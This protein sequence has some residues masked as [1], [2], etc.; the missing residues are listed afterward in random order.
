ME[1]SSERMEIEYLVAAPP[2]DVLR[3]LDKKASSPLPKRWD[4]RLIS[5]LLETSLLARNSRL[6]DLG[7][8]RVGRAEVVEEVLAR[9]AHAPTQ[10][11]DEELE[12][13]A[14]VMNAALSNPTALSFIFPSRWL[15][16]WLPWVARRGSTEHLQTLFL[17]PN[18]PHEVVDDALEGSG[19]FEGLSDERRREILYHALRATPAID[20]PDERSHE[21]DAAGH[22]TQDR[23]WNL[24]LTV[25]PHDQG[26]AN[27]LADALPKLPGFGVPYEWARSVSRSA[28]PDWKEDQVRFLDVVLERWNTEEPNAERTRYDAAP[29]RVIRELI[30]SRAPYYNE[31]AKQLVIA[32]PDV[33]VRRGYYRGLKEESLANLKR[34]H[35]RDGDDFCESAVENPFFY[36]R[37]NHE[38]VLWFAELVRGCKPPEEE[39]EQSIGSMYVERQD[40]L[41][42][43]SPAIYFESQWEAEDPAA[44]ASYKKEAIGTMDDADAREKDLIRKLDGLSAKFTDIVRVRSWLS[45]ALAVALGFVLAK[46]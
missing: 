24:F 46:L 31:A 30:A 42:N 29:Q 9:R 43:E 23:V 16:R 14:A 27:V 1:L 36:E 5:E 33:C 13:D 20:G 11:A 21:Y 4:R 25:D 32:H 17:N 15:I 35:E 2:H 7:L 37:S 6:V 44:H 26:M 18:V 45:L 38:I 34:Y 39:Y 8:A 19:A 3:Y 41:F 12:P 10:G 22:R 40:Q 28:K